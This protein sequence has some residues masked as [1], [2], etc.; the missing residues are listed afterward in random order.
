[1]NAV[2]EGRGEIINLETKK[3]GDVRK[4]YTYFKEGDVIFAKITP[5]MENGK[6]AIAKN[7]INEIGFGSTEFHVIR[8]DGSILSEWIWHYLRQ[9]TIREKA[10]RY[11]I[12]SVGHQRVPKEYLDKLNIPLPIREEQKRIVARIEETFSKIGQINNLRKEIFEKVSILFPSALHKVFSKAD[13][14]G[15]E[16]VK[17]GRVVEPPKSGF[18]C[19][20]KY[21]VTDG[22]PHL[23]PNNIGFNGELDLSKIVHIP[24]DMV[25]LEKYS[26][27][28]G[29]ILFNNTNSKELV[30]RASLVEEELDY[31]F[32][33]HIT[34]LRVDKNMIL[35]EWLVLF[36]NYLWFKR[37]FLKICQKWIGQ[38][39]VNT[40]M[41][42]S[43]NISLPSIEGQKK[44]IEDINK[45]KNKAI[46]L[47]KFQNKT[48]EEI[49]KLKGSVLNKAFRGEL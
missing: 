46:D 27:K 42:K 14:Y 2:D 35:P 21:E 41:L 4:G 37:Y 8:P 33:N 40:K 30:G 19:S 38:A 26:L 22:I 7:L 39:G 48:G 43:T 47:Q 9:K 11:F 1:M 25:D 24:K 28:K 23:R 18:A 5:C 45:V 36:I 29:D 10:V 32:S 31:G 49:E 44:M 34:R 13:K 12:G 16:W 20:K 17:I 15:W 3:L 6:C